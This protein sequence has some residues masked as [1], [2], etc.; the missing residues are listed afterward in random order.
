MVSGGRPP[1]CPLIHG[2]LPGPDAGTA[3]L[4]GPTFPDPAGPPFLF[5]LAMK[6]WPTKVFLSFSIQDSKMPCVLS[7]PG[8]FHVDSLCP[9]PLLP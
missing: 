2:T 3:H 1:K 8:T 5:L 4:T 9:N 7:S 6:A